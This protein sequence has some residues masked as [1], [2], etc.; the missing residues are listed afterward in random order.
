[1]IAIENVRLF[2]ECRSATRNARGPGASDGNGEVLS[3]WR[4]KP[5]TVPAGSSTHRRERGP[6]LWDRW[7]SAAAPRRGQFRSRAHFG[8]I[9]I[10]VAHVEISIDRAEYRWVREHG[11]LHVPDAHAQNDFPMLGSSGTFRTYLAAPLRQHGELVGGLFATTHRD[12]SLHADANQ[13]S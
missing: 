4:A 1:M 9:P 6:G 2:K 8:S 10:P 11:T 5:G 3:S 7:L 13:T 12:A